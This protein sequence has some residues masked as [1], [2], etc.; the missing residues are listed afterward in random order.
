M[1]AVVNDIL[2]TQ[3]ATSLL[4]L[5]FASGLALH[6]SSVSSAGSSNTVMSYQRHGYA[7]DDGRNRVSTPSIPSLPSPPPE[8]YLPPFDPRQ[9]QRTSNTFADTIN[10]RLTANIWPPNQDDLQSDDR[11][12]QVLSRE[13]IVALSEVDGAKFS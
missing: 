7:H 8:S 12:G 11:T 9:L 3:E 10:L 1:F 2:S 13:R 5:R 4:L 6:Q